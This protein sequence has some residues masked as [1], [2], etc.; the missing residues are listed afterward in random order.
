MSPLPKFLHHASVDQAPFL[1]QQTRVDSHPINQIVVTAALRTS[2]FLTQ[3]SDT[4]LRLF[5]TLLTFQKPSGAVRAT[6]RE[7]AHTLGQH[8]DITRTNLDI[9]QKVKWG[10]AAILYCTQ[11]HYH[12]SKQVLAPL[13]IPAPKPA[14]P[15]P[16]VP[17]ATREQ[18]IRHSQ[19]TYGRPIEEV[20][21]EIERQLAPVGLENLSKDEAEGVHL[22]MK[23]GVSQ[24]QA[25]LV[26]ASV[27]LEEIRQ[28]IA[29]LPYRAAKTPAR[30]LVAACLDHYAP[31][32]GYE[33]PKVDIEPGLDIGVQ[34]ADSSTPFTVP[35]SSLTVPES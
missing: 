12:P 33:L 29:W 11:D 30:Y 24:D 16:R 3:L 31:P 1:M 14:P 8:E 26:V 4:Q 5:V 15:Q 20:R 35:E 10:G 21:R 23:Q 13:I 25:R 34:A 7:L 2:G 9:L 32:R 19:Q 18:V 17:M 6:A 22:L 28:Q 27:L